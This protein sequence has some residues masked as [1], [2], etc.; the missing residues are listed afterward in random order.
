[1]EV[2]CGGV[3]W[4]SGGVVE[5]APLRLGGRGWVRSG[6]FMVGGFRYPKAWEQC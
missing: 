2:W 5:G 6:G 4:W 1:V 3:V